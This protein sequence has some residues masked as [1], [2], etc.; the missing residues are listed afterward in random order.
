M[1]KVEPPK[2]VILTW[3]YDCMTLLKKKNLCLEETKAE[4]LEDDQ[5]FLLAFL[6]LFLQCPETWCWVLLKTV[7]LHQF[8]WCRMMF[9]T[10]MMYWILLQQLQKRKSQIPLI[11]LWSPV[12]NLD[13]RP[14]GRT[15]TGSKKGLWFQCW[16]LPWE[17]ECVLKCRTSTAWV[18]VFH[19]ST[20]HVP[21][22][23]NE[24]ERCEPKKHAKFRYVTIILSETQA[25]AHI[26]CSTLRYEYECSNVI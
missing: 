23:W 2:D 6:T 14:S 16:D 1:K 7:F 17:H 11:P 22:T 21:G 8:F 9:S 13:K 26:K 19:Q 18:S 24:Y 15:R 4:L 10:L 3:L 20:P 5:L 12:R 25:S